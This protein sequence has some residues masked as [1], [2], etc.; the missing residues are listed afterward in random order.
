[1]NYAAVETDEGNAVALLEPRVRCSLH[2][3][4]ARRIFSEGGNVVAFLQRHHQVPEH[5]AVLVYNGILNLIR[6][7]AHSVLLL[8]YSH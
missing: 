6:Y 4:P 5:H 7:G 3:R 1:M 8:P 2:R